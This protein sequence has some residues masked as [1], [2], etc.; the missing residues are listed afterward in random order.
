MRYNHAHLSLYKYMFVSLSVYVIGY[1]GIACQRSIC[2]YDCSGNGVC[3]NQESLAERA[4]YVYSTPWDATKIVGCYC[5]TGYRGPACDLQECPSGPDPIGAQGNE[6][7]RDCS[8][9]GLC[10]YTQGI[11]TCF[12]GF[13]GTRCEYM[14][15]LE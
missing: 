12:F 5:D 15:A 8:G 3:L 10:D 11:C 6:V 1:D 9:R 7:G 14:T 4:G 13:F 2:P